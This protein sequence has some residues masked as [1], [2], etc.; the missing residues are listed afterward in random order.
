MRTVALIVAAMFWAGCALAAEKPLYAPAPDWVLPISI[1]DVPAAP[2]GNA[3]QILLLN[4]QSRFG[5]RGD[6]FYSESAMRILSPLGLAAVGSIGGV[7]RPDTETLTIH[8]LRI[9]R[10][11]QTIDLL[12]NGKRFTVIRRETNLEMA[13]LDGT[14]TATLQPEGLRVGDV[15]DWAFTLTRRDPVWKGNSEGGARLIGGR[16][17]GRT[18]IRELWV[19]NKAMRWKTTEGLETPR[20]TGLGDQREIVFDLSNAE[21]PK[22]PRLA[23][24]RYNHLGELEISQ[25]ESWAAVSALMAPL[26]AKAESLPSDSSLRAEIKKIEA[27]APDPKSRAEGAL[28][29]VQQQVRY[30][31]LGMNNGGFIPAAAGLTWRD[32]SP[33]AKVNPFCS[34]RFFK[35]WASR[36][37]LPWSTRPMVTDWTNDCRNWV[38]ST[39]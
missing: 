14:L 2:E 19:S 34:W 17:V 16:P 24:P 37:S 15:V 13:M 35:R 31:S 39:T 38:F 12:A 10:G 8:K 1:P 26:Y 36:P 4:T 21:A 25:F 9:V 23:P 3:L 7:W 29:L 33:T 20:V 5:P 18:F 22:P 28:K 27:G 11:G 6:E 30:L 32:D